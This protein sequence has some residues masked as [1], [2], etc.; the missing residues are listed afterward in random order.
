M[1][2][3][4][5]SAPQ[6]R[7]RCRALLLVGFLVAVTGC[8]RKTVIPQGVQTNAGGLDQN[9]IESALDNLNHLAEFDPDQILD[10]LVRRLNE[11]NRQDKTKVAMQIDGLVATLPDQQRLLDD[12][13]SPKY[14][15]L[16]AYYLRETK[17]MR[18]IATQ[19]CDGVFDDMDK[20]QRLFAWTVDNIDLV[21]ADSPGGEPLAQMP[22]LSVLT[23]TGRPYD[24]AWVFALLA[25]QANLDVVLLAVPHPVQQQPMLW[26]TAF[27]HD[28]KL[29]LFDQFYGVPFL[30]RT[31]DGVATLAE[32][33]RDPELMGQ[34]GTA[35]NP[36]PIT[37]EGIKGRID[38]MVVAER[39]C[40]TRRMKKIQQRLG[41]SL[42]VLTC[43]PSD[44]AARLESIKHVK[45]TLIW[46][47]PY[48]AEAAL[49]EKDSRHHSAIQ[50]RI[51]AFSKLRSG[52]VNPLWSGRIRHLQ[53]RYAST[54]DL[55]N[56]VE[57]GQGSDLGLADR[58]AKSLYLESRTILSEVN[59]ADLPEK[60]REIFARLQI[61]MDEIRSYATYWL[62]NI[63]MD[64]QNFD[65][66]KYYFEETIRN[67]PDSRLAESAK[68]RL[69]RSY[70]AK[71]EKERAIEAYLAVGGEAATACQ[72]RAR[73]LGSPASQE[74]REDAT[75]NS[76][77]AVNGAAKAETKNDLQQDGRQPAQDETED[78]V[79]EEGPA[80]EK[81]KVVDKVEDK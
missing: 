17:F 31:G 55:E 15:L 41:A 37:A 62:G 39:Q 79:S 34:F 80:E 7:I 14:T 54:G 16:D 33:L 23:G 56:T 4:H 5:L 49:F 32:L 27:V 29:Y 61:R 12:L 51:A 52:A 77:G 72:L 81:E 57:D 20:A 75:P 74:Q 66:A 22:W 58:G 78:A 64:E 36:Y 35:N 48:Q 46:R 1:T 13:E 43:R 9:I 63:S 42:G 71:G 47:W 6:S 45:R 26:S 18:D 53:G 76:N 38:A 24:R 69:A 21:P 30:N 67:W 28:G 11:W 8:G 44:L 59:E 73:R 25:R 68:M 3:V 70:E 60:Q 65:L 2:A 19:V 10:Q 40:L 50:Q